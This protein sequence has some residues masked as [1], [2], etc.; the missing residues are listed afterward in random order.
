VYFDGSYRGTSP[1]TV[2]VS[3]TGNP[4]HTIRVTKSGYNDW[5]DSYSGNPSDGEYIYIDAALTPLI[6]SGEGIIRYPP[7]R[8]R[9]C[10][11]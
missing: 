3:S 11:L 5:E 1:V 7:R 4:S 6:G 10:L 8:R 9:E 2:E